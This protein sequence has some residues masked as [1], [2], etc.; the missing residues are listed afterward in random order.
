MGLDLR[1]LAGV[2]DVVWL[3]FDSLRYDVASSALANHRTPNLA[4]WL[5]PIGGWER[6][7]TP[8]TFTLAAHMAFFHGFLP[9]LASAPAAP[10][11]MALAYDGSRTIGP[12]TLCFESAPNVIAGFRSLGYR[13]ICIGGVGFFNRRNPLGNVLP[14]LFCEAHWDP[15]FSVTS[16]PSPVAQVDLAVTLLSKLPR[17]QRVLLYINFSATHTPHR[18]YDKSPGAIE[19]VGTQTA[20]LAHIDGELPRLV[21]AL[22]ARGPIACLMMADHGEAYGED[23][24]YGHRISHPTVTTVPYAELELG[25]LLHA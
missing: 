17:T 25:L 10:R 18:Y 7:E 21:A 20:A 11:L 9:T 16:H 15:A 4:R 6:R 24:R 1:R 23:G 12:Q 8:G 3:V 13:T 19:S 2:A 14:S 5:S 22:T